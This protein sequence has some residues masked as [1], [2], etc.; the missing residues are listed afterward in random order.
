MR[1]SEGSP[2]MEVRWDISLPKKDRNLSNKQT[3]PAYT[4]TG[5]KTTNKDLSKWKE[6]I[7]QN[8]SR[9]KW[10]RF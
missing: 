2:E 10:H 4:M 9:I 7:S 8:Q 6:T 5:G 3:I 1:H